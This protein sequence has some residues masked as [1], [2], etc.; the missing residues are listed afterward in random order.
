[1]ISIKFSVYSA[2]ARHVM[3]ECSESYIHDK[4]CQ[5]FLLTSLAL[6]SSYLPFQARYFPIL[7]FCTNWTYDTLTAHVSS[8]AQ[9]TLLNL[10]PY[11]AI[12]SSSSLE[13]PTEPL[14]LPPFLLYWPID[15][16]IKLCTVTILRVFKYV[17]MY[18]RIFVCM[19]YVC[20]FVCM[21]MSA[22]MHACMCMHAYMYV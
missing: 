22:C 4:I 10:L 15:L 2:G 1:M 18:V 21:Y 5:N 19:F 8:I 6:S 14:Q 13:D 7:Y 17:R 16:Q 20:I 3:L 12:C 11:A 9:L